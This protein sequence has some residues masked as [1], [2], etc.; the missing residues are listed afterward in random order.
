MESWPEMD[1]ATTHPTGATLALGDPSV[2][3]NAMGELE[4]CHQPEGALILGLVAVAWLAL[5]PVAVTGVVTV[6]GQGS[7]MRNAP[8]RHRGSIAWVACPAAW[9]L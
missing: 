6:C 8:L 5:E 4:S 1:S 3:L 2:S 7:G 9:A